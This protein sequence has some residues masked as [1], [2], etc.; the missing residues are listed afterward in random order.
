MYTRP[1]SASSLRASTCT[2]ARRRAARGWPSHT[3]RKRRADKPP[4]GHRACERAATPGGSFVV[5][6][7]QRPPAAGQQKPPLGGP[8]S[9]SVIVCGVESD[10]R[11]RKSDGDGD[12]GGRGGR[13]R[14]FSPRGRRQRRCNRAWLLFSRRSEDCG[15]ETDARWRS[16]G[17]T[18][19]GCVFLATRPPDLPTSGSLRR[20]SGSTPSCLVASKRM[21]HRCL[22]WLTATLDS[23]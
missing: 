3:S 12:G 23:I 8:Q 20:G 22:A 10:H 15:K 21:T 14:S 17:R 4:D 18:T 1:A 2:H 5:F 11:L 7:D 19:A 16:A 13:T 9:E 6:A